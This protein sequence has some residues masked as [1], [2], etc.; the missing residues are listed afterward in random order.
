V[1]ALAAGPAVTPEGQSGDLLGVHQ[2]LV[3]LRAA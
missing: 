2:E 3:A 1:P